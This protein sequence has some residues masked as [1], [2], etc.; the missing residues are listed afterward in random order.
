MKIMSWVEFIQPD[1]RVLHFGSAG[2]LT[3]GLIYPEAAAEMLQQRIADADLAATVPTDVRSYFEGART[4]FL[5]G[6]FSYEL[7][8][9]SW[10]ISALAQEFALGERFMDSLGRE[11]V[12]RHKQ[13]GE[14]ASEGFSRFGDLARA[15]RPGGRRPHRDWVLYDAPGF[16]PSLGWLLNW[17]REHGILATWLGN[18]WDFAKEAVFSMYLSGDLATSMSPEWE[19]W[20][21]EEKTRWIHRE[22]RE[23]WELDQLSAMREVRNE[24]AHPSF[25]NVMDPVSASRQV[26]FAAEFIS[27]LWA[28]GQVPTQGPTQ[29]GGAI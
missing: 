14:S 8:A 27:S 24:L 17:S 16:R 9:V 25:A 5:R 20:S 11:C 19:S 10:T 28:P 13:T 15:V 18:R 21:P 26:H 1:P 2:L 29:E 4:A 22:G 12:F 23:R 3:Q 6:F 7:F